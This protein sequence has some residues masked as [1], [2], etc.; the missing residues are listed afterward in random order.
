VKCPFRDL[1]TAISSAG[2]TAFPAQGVPAPRR[3]GK[4]KIKR[5]CQAQDR[6]EVSGKAIVKFALV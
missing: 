6:R 5:C 1:A 4:A 2:L 3:S